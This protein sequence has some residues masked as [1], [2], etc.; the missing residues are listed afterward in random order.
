M[1]YLTQVTEQLVE[2]YAKMALDP[3]WIDYAR[4]QVK[5]LQEDP[6]GNWTDLAVRVKAKMTE[7]ENDKR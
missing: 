2:H 5:T 4:R 7:I 1:D 3:A 6:S